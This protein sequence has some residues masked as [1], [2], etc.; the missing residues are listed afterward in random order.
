MVKQGVP[1]FA[2]SKIFVY[3]DIG[4]IEFLEGNLYKKFIGYF[5]PITTL[6]KAQKAIPHYSESQKRR[7]KFCGLITE[8]SFQNLKSHFLTKINKTINILKI[9]QI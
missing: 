4:N 5:S 2:I 9:H 6:A 3:I 7:R 1:V 8:K